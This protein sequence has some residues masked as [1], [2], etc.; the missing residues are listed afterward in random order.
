MQPGEYE[1][2]FRVE[3]AHW[4]YLALRRVLRWHLERFQPGWREAA[5]LDAGCGTGGNLA[6]LPGP[7]ARVGLDRADAALAHCRRRGLRAL[8]RGDVSALPFAE[9]SFEVVL[10]ASVIYHQWV[11]DPAVALGEC[12]RVLRPGGLLLLDVPASDALWS[13]HDHAVMTARR[14]RA[15]DLRRLV[16]AS[17]F[18]V[19][20]L[21]HWNT[22]LF[23]AVWAARRLG[24][25][26]EGRD[27]DPVA[28]PGGPRNAL[29]DAAMRIEAAGWRRMALPFGV[30]IHCAARR[31]GR[32]G[33]EG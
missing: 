21:T 15:R 24:L 22:L 23:P 18:E 26:P 5:I 13:A 10:S 3:A 30:S 19:L 12:H 11:A 14:F 9:G 8:V 1:T 32:Y 29:L 17:G 7:G 16:E 6:H 20:R 4:W 27:F 2:L 31:H 33:L 25:S 28:P